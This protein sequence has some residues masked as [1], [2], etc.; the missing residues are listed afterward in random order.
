MEV[1]NDIVPLRKVFAYVSTLQDSHGY[2]ISL[3]KWNFFAKEFDPYLP[4]EEQ[5][6]VEYEKIYYNIQKIKNC[7]E[8]HFDDFLDGLKQLSSKV[9][10][11]RVKESLNFKDANGTNVFVTFLEEIVLPFYN[12]K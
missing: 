10:E 6:R 9:F 8:M 7:S 12:D 4:K 1:F 5:G 2:Y 11:K 3:N